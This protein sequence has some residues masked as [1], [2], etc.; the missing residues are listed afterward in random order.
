[1][2]DFYSEQIKHIDNKERSLE[3]L[4]SR[5]NNP[6]LKEYLEERLNSKWEDDKKNDFLKQFNTLKDNEKRAY[7]NYISRIMKNDPNIIKDF[8]DDLDQL[9]NLLISIDKLEIYAW[10]CNNCNQNSNSWNSTNYEKDTRQNET[11]DKLPEVIDITIL[12]GFTYHNW[13]LIRDYEKNLRKIE[14]FWI[15]KWNSIELNLLFWNIRKKVTITYDDSDW[16]ILI[17]ADWKTKREFI[18]DKKIN[19]PFT[20]VFWDEKVRIKRNENI[21]KWSTD[22]PKWSYTEITM[23][24]NWRLLNPK[25]KR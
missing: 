7:R 15:K 20:L 16:Y 2:A 3:E 13:D 6:Y 17:N 10:I 18:D 4:K 9:T 22:K 1:M 12:N 24:L 25:H 23:Q 19:T 14:N 21:I 5:L 8:D 11:N